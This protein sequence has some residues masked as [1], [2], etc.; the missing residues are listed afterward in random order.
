MRP[1]GRSVPGRASP[2]TSSTRSPA[3][4]WMPAAE[5]RRVPSRSICSADPFEQQAPARIAGRWVDATIR[6]AGQLLSRGR[7]LLPRA[8]PA[9][10][11]ANNVVGQ[12][13]V[14]TF[15]PLPPQTQTMSPWLKVL[16]P[17][18]TAP[19]AAATARSGGD[20]QP[21]RTSDARPRGCDSSSDSHKPAVRILSA[22]CRHP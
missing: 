5:P 20:A 10:A 18:C 4:S 6:P 13:G 16:S 12:P 19:A 7:F 9:R 15:P 14:V 21:A 1:G 22:P 3:R 17:P 11:V 8:H 2:P